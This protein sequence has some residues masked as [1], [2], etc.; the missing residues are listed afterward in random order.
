MLAGA[1]LAVFAAGPVATWY[2]SLI[3]PSA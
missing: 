2:L 3:S 1:L